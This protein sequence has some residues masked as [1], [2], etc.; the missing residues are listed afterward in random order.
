MYEIYRTSKIGKSL[1]Y[2]VDEMVKNGTITPDQGRAI[3]EKFDS[4][5]PRFLEKSNNSLGFKG[6]ILTYNFV[7]GVW[8]FLCKEMTLSVNNVYTSVP[9]MRI[10]A[11]DADTSGES[12]R[13]RRKQNKWKI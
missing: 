9:Y 7:E 5:V 6:K 10:V 8:K 3:L 4:V 1:L 13:R 2:I 11:C 12:S